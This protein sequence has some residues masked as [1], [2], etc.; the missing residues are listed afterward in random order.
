[1]SVGISPHTNSRQGGGQLCAEMAKGDIVTDGHDCDRA[2]V[3]MC[4][5]RACPGRFGQGVM[6]KDPAPIDLPR[7]RRVWMGVSE[8]HSLYNE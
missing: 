1:M 5:R 3:L 7:A 8:G 2:E 4:A 6:R